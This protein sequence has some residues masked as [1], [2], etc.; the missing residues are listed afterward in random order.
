MSFDRPRAVPRWPVVNFQKAF[1]AIDPLSV[2][3]G[4]GGGA[5]LFYV[6]QKF[7]LK[8]CIR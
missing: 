1:A 8:R 7:V 4:I 3:V 5:A 2:V 6:L